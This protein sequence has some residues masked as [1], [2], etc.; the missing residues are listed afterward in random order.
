[1]G[2]LQGPVTVRRPPSTYFAKPGIHTHN[3]TRRLRSGSARRSIIG[4]IRL[5]LIVLGLCGI[6]YYGY[7]LSDQYIYEAYQNWAFDQQISGRHAV[8][9]ADYLREKT[10]FGFL[11]G[12]KPAETPSALTTSPSSA[13]AEIPRPAEGSVLGRVEIPRLNLAAMVREGVDEKTLTIAVGHVPITALPGQPGN[14]A[15]AAHRDTLFRALKDI[16]KDDLVTFQSPSGSYTYRVA[17]TKIVKPSDVA[18]LRS[19]GGGLIRDDSSS[20]PQNSE[21]P[22]ILTMITCYP[23]YYVGSAP[24]RFIVEAKFVPPDNS[25]AASPPASASEKPDLTITKPKAIKQTNA[26][27]LRHN[28]SPSHFAQSHSG[29]SREVQRTES[30][31]AKKRG[32]WHKVLHIS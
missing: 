9:F 32:F 8:T 15:I 31:P 2:D 4:W 7:T 6:G 10:P 17:A 24:K 19:D 14:F 1:M 13:P 22:K 5:L 28:R 29:D 18:I 20:M 25:E 23:F 11:V 12:S 16:K 30:K 21:P 3:V 27:G 26:S